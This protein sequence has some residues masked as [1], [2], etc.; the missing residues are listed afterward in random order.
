MNQARFNKWIIAS[1]QFAR[2]EPFLAPVLQGLGRLD[3]QLIAQ[4]AEF[5]AKTNEERASILTSIQLNDRVTQ[6]YLWVLG[7]YEFIRTVNQRLRGLALEQETGAVKNQFNRLRVP[8]AKLEAARRS[9]DDSP[10]AFPALNESL[11][12]AWQIGPQDFIT[13][14]ELSDSLLELANHFETSAG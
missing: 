1:H 14:R 6:S 3:C 13:R 7:G 11:G 8:L 9:P 2:I 12:I 10:I 5:L 4:D